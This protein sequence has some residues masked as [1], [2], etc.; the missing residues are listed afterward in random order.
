MSEQWSG[1]VVADDTDPGLGALCALARWC[2][3]AAAVSVAV[4]DDDALRYV[5]AAGAGAAAIVG[6]RLGAGRGIAGF[7]AATGQSLIVRD[8]ASDPR[9]AR[10]VGE[11]TGYVPASLQC[12]PVED[13][14]GDVAAVISVLDRSESPTGA[15]APAVPIEQIT[16]LAAALLSRVGAVGSRAGVDTRLANLA[17]SRQARAVAAISAVLDALD[18]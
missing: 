3:G 5:A 18:Q 7:V 1:P 9:F 17:P 11:T 13:P 2:F 15:D 14:D 10:D 6:A 12:V 16:G 4:V 8:V